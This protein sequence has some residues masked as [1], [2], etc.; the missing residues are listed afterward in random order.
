M[1]SPLNLA[2]DPSATLHPQSGMICLLIQGSPPPP[3]PLSTVSRQSFSNSL[4]FAAHL[5]TAGAS[6][7]ALLL[8]LC[9]LQITRAYIIIIIIIIMHISPMYKYIIPLSLT[10]DRPIV[11]KF[12]TFCWTF[13]HVS[14]I[15][16]ILGNSRSAMALQ[17][18]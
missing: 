6:D 12:F 7:S 5:A 18:Q 15:S 9:A 13:S 10:S 2:K 4:P 17:T 8:T 11:P 3:I 1:C 14:F 16:A